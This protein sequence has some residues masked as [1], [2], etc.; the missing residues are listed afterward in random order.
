MNHAVNTLRTIGANDCIFTHA[1]PIIVILLSGGNRLPGAFC[2]V[3]C[4]SN[5]T[6]LI[7]SMLLQGFHQ[8]AA[9][10][11]YPGGF[12]SLLS[13]S[14]GRKQQI[15]GLTPTAICVL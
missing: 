3:E 6:C 9:T 15:I 10:L 8:K 4:Q 13:I 12:D 11:S 1:D 5:L 14:R 2:L 7:L